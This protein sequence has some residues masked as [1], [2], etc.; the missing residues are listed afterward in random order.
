M[1]GGCNATIKHPPS[2]PTWVSIG[3]KIPQPLLATAPKG[4]VLFHMQCVPNHGPAYTPLL[5]ASVHI[6]GSQGPWSRLLPLPFAPASPLL[7]IRRCRALAGV[8]PIV[9][10]WVWRMRGTS[11]PQEAHRGK[12][13]KL[14][15]IGSTSGH[16]DHWHRCRIAAP[17]LINP[18]LCRRTVTGELRVCDLRHW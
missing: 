18:A 9:T 6:T 15:S 7:H 11:C 10:R 12:L 14:R 2:L 5:P 4:A 17:F 8:A 3:L 1:A 13:S 16:L